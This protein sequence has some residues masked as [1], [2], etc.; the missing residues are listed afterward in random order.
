MVAEGLEPNRLTKNQLTEEQRKAIGQLSSEWGVLDSAEHLILKMIGKLYET[1]PPKAKRPSELVELES[2][3]W[4]I[5]QRK[6]EISADLLKLEEGGRPRM[7]RPGRRSN[8]FVSVRD[9]LI[10][11]SKHQ[12]DEDICK[13]LDSELK[14]TRD[15]TPPIGFPE[16]WTEKY[17]VRSYSAAYGH[18]DCKPLMQK[19]ISAAKA[20][21]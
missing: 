16:P 10:R 18:P 6:R 21:R 15:D 13:E 1:L 20:S 12:R 2:R 5:L 11:Q 7:R 17:K 9:E 19:L 14:N 3:Q 8:P 4:E